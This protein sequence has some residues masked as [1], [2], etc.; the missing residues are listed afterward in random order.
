MDYNIVN[1]VVFIWYLI[2]T[3]ENK[4]CINEKQQCKYYKPKYFFNDRFERDW[5]KSSV[6]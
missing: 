3:N 4:F 1:T 2:I 6:T 5:T